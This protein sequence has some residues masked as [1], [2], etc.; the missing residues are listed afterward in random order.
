MKAKSATFKYY[1]ETLLIV[2]F[3]LLLSCR[4]TPAKTTG[5]DQVPQ[6][7]SQI[8]PPSFPDQDFF[9]TDFGAKGDRSTDCTLAFRNAIEACHESGGG[10][11]LVTEGEFL[12][13]AIHLKSNVNLHI[14]K[15]ATILFSKDTQKYLPVVHT[16]FEGVECMNYSPLIYAFEQVNIAVTGEGT[17][18]G[19][20]GLDAW[21]QWVQKD[22]FGWE[23]GMPDQN[24]DR[25][26][27]F[28]MGEDGIP[29]QNRIF[30][31]GHYLRINFIQFYKC[32]NIL[33]EG[34]TIKRSPMWE[35]HPVLS[36]NVTVRKVHVESH[37]P[38]N[39]G[40]NP[41][42]S[43]NVLIEDCYFDTGDDCIAIKSGRNGDGRRI[44]APCENI[45]VRNCDM[46]DG[47]G[48]VVIGS[49]MTGGVRNVFIEKCR[50][51]SPNLDRALRIKTNSLRG[52]MVENVYMRDVQVG[53]V[54]DAVIWI[55]FHYE[56][57]DIGNHTPVVRNVTIQNVTSKKSEYG[58]LLDGYA[59]SPIANVLLESCDFQGV[60][61]GNILKHV[62]GLQ[63][64]NVT[65]NG[66]LQSS[67]MQIH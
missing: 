19:Q 8:V 20:A 1:L 23:K 64:K 51:D 65:I 31:D 41:E 43:K 22:L 16:R 47:H 59:R 50:M 62:S 58:L 5:W 38:N 10:R 46:K 54:A 9:V 55:Y 30:G 4:S 32:K 7:L 44:N 52:G 67:A 15:N 61:K 39:D 33:I 26:I 27:L 17:V 34:V 3:F 37:G 40:C 60:A 56:D 6:I 12:T 29:V 45:L 36:E 42:C 14:L 13:G 63:M 2:H 48:G 21:W 25:E 57:G 49:E 24:M 66:E 11:V 28:K 18:D 35:I 53:E